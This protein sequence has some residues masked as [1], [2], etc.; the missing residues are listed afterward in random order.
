M[1]EGQESTDSP[2]GADSL[3]E[4]RR[5]FVEQLSRR[6]E[7]LRQALAALKREPTQSGR[8]DTLLRRVHAVASAARVLGF[9]SAAEALIEAERALSRSL[10]PPIPPADLAV[11]ERMLE[12]LPTLVHSAGV[13]AA[14]AGAAP[15]PLTVLVVGSP[16]LSAAL[17]E[18]TELDLE[19]VSADSADTA[20]DRAL[21]VDPDVSVVDCDT[22]YAKDLLRRFHG[23][24]SLAAI[25]LIAVATLEGANAAAAWVA[26]GATSVVGKPVTPTAL[27]NAL[28]KEVEHSRMQGAAGPVGEAT[29]EEV[30]ERLG[31][32][33]RRGLVDAAT[34]QARSTR[35]AFGE[36]AELLAAVWGAVA[37]VRQVVERE[38]KGAVRFDPTGPEGAFPVVAW[39]EDR[40]AAER[41]AGRSAEP[42]SLEGRTVLIVDDDPAVV[43]FLSGALK[44]V[45]ARVLEAHDGTKALEI[46]QREWPDLVVSDVVM[47]GIDGISLC[48]EIKRDAGVRDVPVIL[49]SWK[50]D[51][52]QRVRELG[53]DADGYLRKEAPA[54]TV[55]ERVR[56]ALRPRARVEDRMRASHEVSGR[57]DG[58]SPRL[59]LELAARVQKNARV[60]L[61]DPAFVYEVQIRQGAIR[62]ITRTGKDGNFERGTVL[63]A[64]LLG[65]NSGRFTVAP[66]DS[67]CRT[68]VADS[69]EDAVNAA[70]DR[71]RSVQRVLST[72]AI[73]DVRRVNFDST[74]LAGYLDATPEPARGLL[75]QLVDGASPAELCA[76]HG[77]SPRLLE[78]LLSDLARRGAVVDVELE[79]TRPAR[80]E[81]AEER[82]P[83]EPPRKVV[84]PAEISAP[85]VAEKA[86]L[87]PIPVPPPAAPQPDTRAP[88]AAVF[89]F[90]LTPELPLATA[91]PAPI[92]TTVAGS[93]DAPALPPVATENDASVDHDWEQVDSAS[94]LSSTDAPGDPAEGRRWGGREKG[95]MPGLGRVQGKAKAGGVDLAQAIFGADDGTPSPSPAGTEPKPD[96]APVTKPDAPMNKS[97]RTD[98][99]PIAPA[100]ASASKTASAS[101]A[102]FAS[103][104]RV[105]GVFGLAA[106]ASFALV[107]FVL[108]P[109][110]SEPRHAASAAESV[111]VPELPPPASSGSASS[112][113]AAAIPKV[114][115][116]GLPPGIGPVPPDKGLLEVFTGDES[117]IYEDGVF[118]GRGPLRRDTV[119]PGEHEIMVHKE[120]QERRIRVE[121]RAG[122]RTRVS[123]SD[124]AEAH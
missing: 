15:G 60:T 74:S 90:A 47:P 101:A 117:S 29:L 63:V 51:L 57:L 20:A 56:E 110:T 37:R 18:N 124:S 40:S 66:D 32:E 3:S 59:I 76:S 94:L 91:T 99:S 80:D 17:T 53:A 96:S 9:A 109:L 105:I 95:T 43:W 118:I 100:V 75:H 1:A 23:E 54:S 62:S 102:P 8:R 67:V 108:A 31:A 79:T 78:D 73:T 122:A 82:S 4:S 114:D 85:E 81:P 64:P 38:S 87:P 103:A 92:A 22:P 44:A 112:S 71:A 5:D 10:K 69:F 21:F 77:A 39:T 88:A 70:I 84:E 34:P 98:E 61:R 6:I 123:Y 33:L 26:L 55:M 65:V 2:A 121:V 106:A 49:L 120:S 42:T 86:V 115:Q 35:V 89:T 13:S 52:L 58:L 45:G 30:A 24:P 48:R 41:G 28:I 97:R 12:V 119:S 27:Q 111:A 68:D 11:V 50:E 113:P 46:V 19:C 7:G 104:V 83:A 25:P 93:G 107:R 72:K 14:N 36:G 116:L 16:S